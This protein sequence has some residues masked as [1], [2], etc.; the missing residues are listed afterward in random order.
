MPPPASMTMSINRVLSRSP[1]DVFSLRFTQ[2]ERRTLLGLARSRK[3]AERRRCA[4]W[5]SVGS[6]EPRNLAILLAVADALILNSKPRL[7]W[8]VLGDLT[9][10]AEDRPEDVWPLIVKWGCVHNPDIRMGIACCLLEHV[11]EYHFEEFFE[12]AQQVIGSG[13]RR[14]AATLMYCYKFGQAEETENARRFDNFISSLHLR[15]WK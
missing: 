6:Q 1:D 12:R 5:V 4:E 9:R 14:F 2:D 7:R 3:A 13:N 10:F 15:R 11:L 8:S